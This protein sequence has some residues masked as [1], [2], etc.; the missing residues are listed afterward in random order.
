MK[1]FE[2]LKILRKQSNLTQRKIAEMLDV[3]ERAYQ[4]YE[5]GTRE[6]N[7]EK[8]IKLADIFNVSIDYLVCRDCHEEHADER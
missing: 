2:N 4:H 1:F 8:L 3:S 6:P 5:G 7:I